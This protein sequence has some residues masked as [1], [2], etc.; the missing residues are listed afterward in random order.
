MGNITEEMICLGLKIM[1]GRGMGRG[2]DET[3]RMNRYVSMVVLGQ[4]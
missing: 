4:Y 2:R 3:M 1:W